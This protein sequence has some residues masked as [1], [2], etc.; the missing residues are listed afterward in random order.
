NAGDV[1]AFVRAQMKKQGIKFN[2]E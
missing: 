1:D 2:D